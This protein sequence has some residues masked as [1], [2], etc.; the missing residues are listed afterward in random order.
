MRE[1]KNVG[2]NNKRKGNN[3]ELQVIQALREIGYKG[4]VSSRS[5]N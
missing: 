4:C 3:F 2:K 5:I 1:S